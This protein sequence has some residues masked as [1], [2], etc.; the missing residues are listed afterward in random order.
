MLDFG[1]VVPGPNCVLPGGYSS[2]DSGGNVLDLLRCTRLS[3]GRRPKY[4][5]LQFFRLRV[6]I[7]R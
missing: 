6:V 2:Y 5:T 3:L 1:V 4:I 7:R